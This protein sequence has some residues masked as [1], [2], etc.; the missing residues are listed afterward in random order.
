MTTTREDIMSTVLDKLKLTLFCVFLFTSMS[1][2]AKADKRSDGTGKEDIT[3]A[4]DP[5][6]LKLPCDRVYFGFENDTTDVYNQLEWDAVRSALQKWGDVLDLSF[7]E[8]TSAGAQLTFRW[9]TNGHLPMNL[10]Y[11]KYAD[12]SNTST[13]RRVSFNDYWTW[14]INP[15]SLSSRVD[16]ETIALYI[17][18]RAL[19][20]FNPV[21][22][23]SVL[24]FRQKGDYAGPLQQLS[25]TD[26]HRARDLYKACNQF[27]TYHMG[28]LQPNWQGH[29]IQTHSTLLA[30]YINANKGVADLMIMT[31][32]GGQTG[33]WVSQTNQQWVNSQQI[34]T[35]LANSWN[36]QADDKFVTGDFDGDGLDNLLVAN[37]DGRYQTM[38]FNNVSTSGPFGWTAQAFRNNGDIDAGDSLIAGNFDHDAADELL[39][40]KT[41]GSYYTMDYNTSTAN[42]DIKSNG[43]ANTGSIH[44]WIISWNDTYTVGDFDGDGRDEL[45]AMNP[46]GWHHTMN[47][48]D[49][50]G[51]RY[52]EGNGSGNIVGDNAAI[53][54]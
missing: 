33:A 2:V 9:D 3:N 17:T 38:Y 48:N 23:D 20:L 21:G 31:A 11:S 1:F 47:F 32:S 44:W 35:I 28:S 34:G 4:W 14:G 6:G 53:K 15:S 19:G 5:S 27:G 8:V 24:Q 54:L 29:Q 18:G 22:A 26:T 52:I 49:S 46:N 43:T 30:P 13:Q 10:T 51:W 36:I 40:I 39:L 41:N 16:V 37:P 12:F 45:L 42:W 25:L 7:V 50:L